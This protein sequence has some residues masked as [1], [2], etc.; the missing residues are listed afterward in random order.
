MVA[1][2]MVVVASVV[3]PVTTKV[4]VEVASVTVRASI[5]AVAAWKKVAKRLVEEAKS[6][7]K[8]DA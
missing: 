8:F 2:E 7:K 4:L 6:A 1:D 5:K 3:V